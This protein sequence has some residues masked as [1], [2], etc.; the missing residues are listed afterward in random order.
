MIGKYFLSDY[1][2]KKKKPRVEFVI[3]TIQNPKINTIKTTEKY[4]TFVKI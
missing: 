4:D 1:K 2:I 3:K